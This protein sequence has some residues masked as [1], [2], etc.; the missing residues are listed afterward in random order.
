MR[1]TLFG[2]FF[3]FNRVGKADKKLL[4]CPHLLRAVN[5]YGNVVKSMS[6]HKLMSKG[7]LAMYAGLGRDIRVL[8]FQTACT[9]DGQKAHT[10][11]PLYA[12]LSTV[13]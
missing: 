1:K 9:L 4:R 10:V 5:V 8:Q 3:L 13:P 12:S 2:H 6:V 7:T 11:Y